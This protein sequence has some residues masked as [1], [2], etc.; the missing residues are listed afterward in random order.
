M[1]RLTGTV[2]GPGRGRVV[3]DEL[4]DVI[5]DELNQILL[6]GRARRTRRR[7]RTVVGI[8]ADAAEV[9]G[10]VDVALGVAPLGAPLLERFFG[11][12]LRQPR[13]IRCF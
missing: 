5:L 8:A 4:S 1:T 2:T 9:I 11:M 3:V 12:P 6:D 10:A 13:S 7:R